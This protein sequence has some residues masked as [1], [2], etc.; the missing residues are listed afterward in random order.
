MLHFIYLVINIRLYEIKIFLWSLF[1]QLT[2]SITW[3]TFFIDGCAATS[4]CMLMTYYEHLRIDKINNHVK[5]VYDSL[6]PIKVHRA[7]KAFTEE[8]NQYCT[9]IIAV[10]QFWKYAYLIFLVTMLPINLTI[11]HQ[12]LFED[13]SLQLRLFFVVCII[14]TDILL[15]GVQY[16]FALY[17]IKIH[18][19][20]AKLSRLQWC[21]NGYPF[22]TRLKWKLIM[23]FERLTSAKHRIGF[24]MGS[25]V[26]TMPLFAQVTIFSTTQRD[27][28][29]FVVNHTP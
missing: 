6:D 21:L 20:Y 26:F 5:S 19:M 7:V 14:V 3:I 16:C 10:N 29:N 18:S 23:C 4:F 8:H 24:T 25:I 9:H 2:N 28:Y 15:F 1:F 11:L 17:S 22:R 12:L 13:I 27:L